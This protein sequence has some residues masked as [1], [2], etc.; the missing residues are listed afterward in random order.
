MYIVEGS[1]RDVCIYIYYVC[2][3][4]TYVCIQ[5]YWRLRVSPHTTDQPAYVLYPHTDSHSQ[6]AGWGIFY[7][8]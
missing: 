6:H 5:L 8:S 3:V 1:H 7:P 4:R 2:I